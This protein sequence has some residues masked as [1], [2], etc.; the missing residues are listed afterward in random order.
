MIITRNEHCKGFEVDV[1]RLYL[2]YSVE[3][4]CQKCGVKQ[5]MNLEEDYISYPKIGEEVKLYFCCAECDHEF[6]RKVKFDVSI[7]NI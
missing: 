6:T 4:D 5:T 2:P 7:T 1:K 3:E